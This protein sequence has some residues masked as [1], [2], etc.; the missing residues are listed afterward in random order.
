MPVTQIEIARELQVSQETVSAALRGDPRCKAS[1]RKQVL[2]AAQRLGYRRNTLAAGLRGGPTASIGVVW[3]FGEMWTGDAAI[4]LDVLNRAQQKGLATYQAQRSHD[5]AEMKRQIQNLISRRVDALVIEAVDPAVDDPQV[6]ALLKQASAVISLVS[7]LKDNWLGDQ[8]VHDRVP[9]IR[10]IVDH[11]V[12][13]GRVRP[14]IMLASGNQNNQAKLKVFVDRLREHGIAHDPLIEL[15]V[16]KTR[17]VHGS[18]DYLER[19]AEAL[20]A[21]LDSGMNF[22]AVLGINDTGAL[23]VMKL[24]KDRGVSVPN[25]VAVVGFNNLDICQ[26]WD[27]MLASVDRRQ[28]AAAE[29]IEQVLSDRLANNEAPSQRKTIAM[30]FLWRASAGGPP[31]ATPESE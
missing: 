11:F 6:V 29:I 2:E 16:P 1:T 20:N 9:V 15:P 19:Y 14:A 27:P 4:G 25:D 31:S 24:L 13:S 23:T 28:L 8:V 26:L 30:E 10:Q 18:P 3:G 12:A 7:Q 17:L 21:A 22:D 5:P